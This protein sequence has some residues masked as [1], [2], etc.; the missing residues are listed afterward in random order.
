MCWLLSHFLILQSFDSFFALKQDRFFTTLFKTNSLNSFITVQSSQIIC[1]L[2]FS[3]NC[4]L[5]VMWLELASSTWPSGYIAHITIP[6]S[7]LSTLPTIFS[8]TS[9]I[10]ITFLNKIK[11]NSDSN[12]RKSNKRIRAQQICLKILIS[13]QCQT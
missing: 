3:R 8:S 11:R 1:R 6:I 9:T 10:Q 5:P 4:K 12:V 13:Y 2:A 7:Q